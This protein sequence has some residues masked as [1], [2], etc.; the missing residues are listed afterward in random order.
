M[1]RPMIRVI[2]EIKAPDIFIV[3]L[4]IL[5]GIVVAIFWGIKN[6]FCG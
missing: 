4:V 2:Y 6:A 5:F 3:C 1:L